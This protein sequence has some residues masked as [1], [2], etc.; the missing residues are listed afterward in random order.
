MQYIKR[1]L[2]QVVNMQLAYYEYCD[3][4]HLLIHSFIGQRVLN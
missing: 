3:L 1:I 4:D 2:V